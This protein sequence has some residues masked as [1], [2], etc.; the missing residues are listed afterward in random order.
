MHHMVGQLVWPGA[1]V[2]KGIEALCSVG[3]LF[4]TLRPSGLY[5]PPG[6]SVHEDSPG[7]NTGVGCH[8]LLQGSS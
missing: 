5:S 1:R 8:T 7:K 2:G 4:L 6:S 3:Q